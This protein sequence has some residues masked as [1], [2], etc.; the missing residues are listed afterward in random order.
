MRPY[1]ERNPHLCA[2]T[3]LCEGIARYPDHAVLADWVPGKKGMYGPE[4]EVINCALSNNDRNAI[5]FL[6]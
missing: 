5:N 1:V 6:R 2:H 3:C 4:A